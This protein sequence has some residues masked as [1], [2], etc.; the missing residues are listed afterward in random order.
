MQTENRHPEVGQ[1]F[2]RAVYCLNDT[3]SEANSLA[4]STARGR[5]L[6]QQ[7][8]PVPQLLQPLVDIARRSGASGW[9]VWV[10][11]QVV[12]VEMIHLN[13]PVTADGRCWRAMHRHQ[14]LSGALLAGRLP[15][16]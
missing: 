6:H 3:L 16:T 10:P 1:P 9:I 2:E 11:M 4:I 14:R 12:L 15:S 7:R 5:T 13:T 8:Q